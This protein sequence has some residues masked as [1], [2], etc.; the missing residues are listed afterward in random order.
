MIENGLEYSYITTGEAFVFLRIDWD[1]PTT[2]LYHVAVPSDEVAADSAGGD[3]F[4]FHRTAVSQVL[5]LCLLASRSKQRTLQGRILAK[6]KLKVK[7]IDD[8]DILG[9]IPVTVRKIMSSPAFRGPRKVE[10]T[11][12]SPIVTRQRTRCKQDGGQV[13]RKDGDD[14]PDTPSKA[15]GASGVGGTANRGKGKG[16]GKAGEGKKNDSSSKGRGRQQHYCTQECLVGIVR[17][18]SL[19]ENCPNVSLH[20]KHGRRHAINQQEFLDLVQKQLAEDLDHNCEPLGLQGARGALFKVTLVSHGYVLVGKGTVQAFV[21]D[22]RHEGDVYRRLAK[23]QGV[24]V[25]VCLGNIDLTEWYY[26]DVGVRILHM[27]LMS[28]GGELADEDESVKGWQGLQRE[29]R[30]TVAEVR[31]AGVD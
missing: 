26:L 30:R 28:W 24:V 22:L 6:S 20:R 29:I 10:N 18:S 19:D 13:S 4:A 25:P 7:Q 1:D 17:R 31:R 3:A 5:G 21:P 27:L 9:R 8:Q 16:R 11:R 15:G 12:D 14:D 2:L 23:L